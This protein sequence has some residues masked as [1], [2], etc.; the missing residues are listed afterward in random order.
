MDEIEKKY[1][2]GKFTS[3]GVSPQLSPE[4]PKKLHAASLA[5]LFIIVGTATILALLVSET[6]ILSTPIQLAKQYSTKYLFSKSSLNVEIA[7]QPTHQINLDGSPSEEDPNSNHHSI[8]VQSED[9]EGV[10]ENTQIQSP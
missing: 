1:F 4:S 5:G 8:Q 6:Y 3:L 2:N 9:T 7:P 10:E